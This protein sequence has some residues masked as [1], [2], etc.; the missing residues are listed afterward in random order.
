MEPAQAFRADAEALATA[1]R[2]LWR[3]AQNVTPDAVTKSVEAGADAPP[4]RLD[5]ETGFAALVE[6]H[7]KWLHL[8]CYRMV[9]SYDDADDLVQETLLKAWRDRSGF[10]GRAAA[11]TWL[12]RIATNVVHRPPAPDRPTAAEVRAGARLRLR[13]R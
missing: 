5:N 6:P 11:R 12:Y 10:Q 8:H 2:R 1:S 3:I 4:P 13:T 9:G 7:R